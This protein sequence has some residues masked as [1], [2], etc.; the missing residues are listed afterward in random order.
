MTDLK[1]DDRTAEK[2]WDGGWVSGTH[3]L[4]LFGNLLITLFSASL[5]G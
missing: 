4:T 3:F 2:F 1:Q 5:L